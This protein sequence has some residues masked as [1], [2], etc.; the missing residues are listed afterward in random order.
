MLKEEHRS[1]LPN[2]KYTKITN[3]QDG[4]YRL[5]V[6]KGAMQ[7]NLSSFLGIEK[8]LWI[9][10]SQNLVSALLALIKHFDLQLPKSGLK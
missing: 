4:S 3:K 8:Q 9:H 2:L 6:G 5:T 1:L 10:N 7:T